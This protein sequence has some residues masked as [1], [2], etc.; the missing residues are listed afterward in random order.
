MENKETSILI[1]EDDKDIVEMLSFHLKKNNYT[2][3]Y[4]YNG[5]NGLNTARENNP[6]LILLELMFKLKI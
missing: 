2:I 3:L 1:I 4:S 6:D 5:E